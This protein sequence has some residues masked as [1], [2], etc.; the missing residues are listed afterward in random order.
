MKKTKKLFGLLL[1]AMIVLPTFPMSAAAAGYDGAY[2]VNESFPEENFYSNGDYKDQSNGIYISGNTAWKAQ[3]VNGTGG[4]AAE[5][6]SVSGTVNGTGQRKLALYPLSFSNTADVLT[7]EVSVYVEDIG[8]DKISVMFGNG[9]NNT[10]PVVSFNADGSIAVGNGANAVSK[11]ITGA[12]KAKRWYKVAFSLNRTENTTKVY[13]NGDLLDTLSYVPTA[14][15]RFEPTHI[16]SSDT[17]ERAFAFD[18]YKLYEAAYDPTSDAVALPDNID[19]ENGVINAADG[20]T[21]EALTAE[22]G[23]KAVIYSDDSYSAQASELSNKSVAVI[24]SESGETLKYYTVSF[25]SI[26][27]NAYLNEDFEKGMDAFALYGNDSSF[28]TA[29]VSGF[30]GKPVDEKV[31]R[32][33]RENAQTGMSAYYTPFAWTADN[34]TKQGYTDDVITAEMSV[35][36]DGNFAA[37]VSAL[38]DM[39]QGSSSTNW[40]KAAAVEFS[41]LGMI[42]IRALSETK[43]LETDYDKGSWY[44]VAITLDRNEKKARLYINGENIYTIENIEYEKAIGDLR[45]IFYSDHDAVGGI[46]N[47]RI[48]PW[49]YDPQG[50][51]LSDPEPVTV[52]AGTY[53]EDIEGAARVIDTDG[54]IVT[55]MVQTGNRAVYESA[56]GEVLK[57][58]Q[59]TAEG[60][61]IPT[62]TTAPSVE[63]DATTADLGIAS[64]NVRVAVREK[65]IAA[66]STPWQGNNW[67]VSSKLLTSVLESSEGWTLSYVG[68]D[69]QP[70]TSDYVIGGYIKAE[71][72]G[73]YAYIPVVTRTDIV[74]VDLHN[75]NNA[76]YYS[77]NNSEKEDIGGLGGKPEDDT[78]YSLR[79]CSGAFSEWACQE[80]DFSQKL[81]RAYSFNV[82]FTVAFNAYADG[83]TV[84]RINMGYRTSA[85]RE[86]FLWEADG[87][88]KWRNTAEG[89]TGEPTGSA[90]GITRGRWHRFAIT[91]D[92][93]QGSGIESIQTNAGRLELYV[94]G[95]RL[96]SSLF[97]SN[98][99]AIKALMVGVDS[100]STS[101]RV[102]FDDFTAWTGE[103]DGDL[104]GETLAFNV[105]DGITFNADAGY[106][107]VDPEAYAGLEELK[108]AL[109]TAIGNEELEIYS[110]GT[111]E[112][113]AATLETGNVVI[114]QLASGAYHYLDVRVEGKDEFNTAYIREGFDNVKIKNLA[115]DKLTMQLYEPNESC[116]SLNSMTDIGGR[117]DK[118]LVISSVAGKAVSNTTNSAPQIDLS[119]QSGFTNEIVTAECSLCSVVDDPSKPNEGNVQVDLIQDKDWNK[120][121]SVALRIDGYIYINN[122][123]TG[124]IFRAN[125]WYKAAF[126]LDR[127]AKTGRVYINGELL[128][129]IE[130]FEYDRAATRFRASLGFDL[131]EGVSK[132]GTGAFDDYRIYTVEY[133]PS[134][135]VIEVG[136][137]AP[138]K[139]IS[140]LERIVLTDGATRKAVT[141]ALRT[142][143]ASIELYEDDWYEDTYVLADDDVVKEDNI[144]VLRSASGEVIKYIRKGE[145]I[146]TQAEIPVFVISGD[147]IT[148]KTVVDT[149]GESTAL[150]IAG[151]DSSG[152]LRQLGAAEITAQG[153]VVSEL[154]YNSEY[155]YTAYVWSGSM[156][157]ITGAAS[158][159]AE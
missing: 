9:W 14:V 42:K 146:P 27:D 158:Y 118:A 48:Y 59:I 114:I 66:I 132:N 58:A 99:D 93:R 52:A 81:G 49:A 140:D 1:S 105:P 44:K 143:A 154:Q 95:Q 87:T 26:W 12:F 115:N 28:S 40:D 128:K 153:E 76:G 134:D 111:F 43:E 80:I 83:D 62:P 72:Q 6:I 61:P 155:T 117:S 69:K 159:K 67:R 82:P 110:D 60:E 116:Y 103:Y 79:V 50:D 38:Q 98:Q 18:D 78:A 47:A 7:G 91:W 152:V 109:D 75:E 11:T 102:A 120:A 127:I 86:L 123:N 148:A 71:K 130:D 142:N 57:Y 90:S 100:D 30:G 29:I 124:R 24:T 108:T 68:E 63:V 17:S 145:D 23:D 97:V 39:P 96:G 106:M 65:E 126:V 19:E 51:L 22:L 139:Y 13:L 84:M 54:N 119:D 112:A 2:L 113:K 74:S 5:D 25:A 149:V 64:S 121:L 141:D 21:V 138:I 56:S 122:E 157:P 45:A 129:T 144:L 8:S 37:S 92:P 135:D 107:L 4:R 131:S 70:L 41:D 137:D 101:G 88:L 33:T 15:T 10:T 55:G 125:Q 46:D 85:A 77:G 53:A 34:S 35:Y 73:Q 136:F 20:T 150:I 151:K 94:D 147:R 36:A 133:D 89:E 3:K 156:S 32:L 31:V 16:A 104:L